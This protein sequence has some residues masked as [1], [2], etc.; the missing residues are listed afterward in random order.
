MLQPVPHIRKTRADALLR[1]D[2]NRTGQK[3]LPVRSEHPRMLQPVPHIRKTRADA[4]LRLDRNRTGQKF[5]GSQKKSQ[6]C[7]L[8]I[9]CGRAYNQSN[10]K[11]PLH[12]ASS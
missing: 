5:A 8:F 12:A 7:P 2:R 1:L 11:K 6:F 4:L 10:P 9:P 3:F